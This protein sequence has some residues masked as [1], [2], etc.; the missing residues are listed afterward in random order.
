MRKEFRINLLAML[1]ILIAAVSFVVPAFS[2]ETYYGVVNVET[3]DFSLADIATGDLGGFYSGDPILRVF[4]AIFLAGVIASAV[5]PLGGYM[6]LFGG[7]SVLYRLPWIG[8][9]MLPRIPSQHWV[10]GPGPYLMVL[11]AM[12]V[13]TSLIARPVLVGR[14]F[15]L[16]YRV[17]DFVK[18]LQSISYGTTPNQETQTGSRLRINPACLVGV[19]LGILALALSWSGSYYYHGNG[20]DLL[21]GKVSIHY[22]AVQIVLPLQ[23]VMIVY[24]IGLISSLYSPL[25][26]TVQFVS[27][28]VIIL[29]T[30]NWYSAGPWLGVVS[31]MVTVH[32]LLMPVRYGQ[33]IPRLAI[34]ENLKTFRRV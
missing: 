2:I 29:A 25:G 33:G 15:R 28:L 18:G 27:S 24:L 1:G 14:S 7:L 8:T 21:L 9:V 4:V 10:L 13:L 31:S 5:T 11:G 19:L 32:S 12:I 20:F 26:A 34:T 16:E 30:A 23:M 17:K 6:L 22:T 3:A